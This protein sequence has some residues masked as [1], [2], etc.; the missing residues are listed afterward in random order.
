MLTGLIFD[1]KPQYP[2][3]PGF[4][5]TVLLPPHVLFHQSTRFSVASHR[6]AEESGAP[7]T[8][9]LAFFCRQTIF[10]LYQVYPTACWVG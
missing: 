1:Q 9:K 8:D 4:C 10:S 5:I 2:M 7:Q 6:S 3:K